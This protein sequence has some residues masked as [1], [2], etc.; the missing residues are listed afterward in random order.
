WTWIDWYLFVI[1]VLL[2]ILF[3]GEDN[4]CHYSVIS[5]YLR[6]NIPPNALNDPSAPLAYHSVF[7]A[8]AALVARAFGA[9]HRSAIALVSVACFYAAFHALQALSRLVLESDRARQ[10][11][12]ALFLFGFG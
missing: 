5:T 2:L 12:R 7:D 3:N 4:A 6:G 8:A 1:V 9:G 11:G 10:I